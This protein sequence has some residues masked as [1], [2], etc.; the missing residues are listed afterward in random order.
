MSEAVPQ[1]VE[2]GDAVIYQRLQDEAVLLDMNTQKYYGLDTVATDMWELLLEH[3]D[4]DVVVQR[5]SA[6]YDSEEVTLRKDL[7]SL[8]EN[9]VSVQLLKPPAR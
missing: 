6:I 1:R 5:L 2:I 9:L 7:I 4:V 8:V 3:H